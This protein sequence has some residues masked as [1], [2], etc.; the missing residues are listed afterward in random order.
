[1]GIQIGEE[2]TVVAGH[3][4]HLLALDQN[5]HQI[6]NMAIDDYKALLGLPDPLQRIAKGNFWMKMS[7]KARKSYR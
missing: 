7:G 3:H 6:I 4:P 5:L 2:V 1:M